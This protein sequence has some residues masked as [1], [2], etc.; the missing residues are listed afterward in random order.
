MLT[1]IRA[2]N[3]KSWKDTGEIR[4]AP[5]TGFFGT[6]SSGKT[7]LLQM[8]LLLKQTALSRDINLI[9][10]TYWD[11]NDYLNL[12]TLPELIFAAENTLH[13]EVGWQLAESLPLPE[14]EHVEPVQHLTFSTE[15]V[16]EITELKQRRNY[17]QG[18][19]YEGD[20]GFLAE[21]TRNTKDSYTVRAE[22]NGSEFARP[23]GRPR[24]RFSPPIKCYGFSSEAVLYYT[25]GS[26]LNQLG[27]EFERLFS[28][29]YHLGPLREYP[30]RTYSW[31]GEEPG[32]VG[33][34]GETAIPALLA[35]GST[36]V[37][38]TGKNRQMTLEQRIAKWLAE[39]GLV[40]SFRTERI[41]EN[42]PY[43]RVLVRRH[44]NSAEVPLTDVGFGVSQVLPVLVL[45]YY[46]PEGSTLVLEQPEIH[47]HPAVQSVLA[48]VLIDA[49]Q[50]RNIQVILESHSEYL[51]RRIQRHLSENRLE[52]DK[53]A[54]YFCNY[55]EDR[56]EIAPL[57]LDMFGNIQNWPKDFFGD[58]TGEMLAIA[59]AGLK[60]RVGVG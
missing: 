43:Y 20:N 16:T 12:G 1:K 39:M 9:L 45:A 15:I 28:R 27:Y 18:I 51:L 30:Q 21:M 41:S 25:N 23:Q 44:K 33:L 50:R 29:V 5:L 8:L 46:C 48:D 14:P 6:N 60:R 11:R 55:V 38:K 56:S 57:E 3:F 31:A 36:R 2:Q 10:R 26:V 24:A 40:A 52:V 37:Y 54:F 32:D 49:I 58:L 42:A 34:K 59:E 53:T 35:R 4:I 19:R 22:V 7:S 13:F 17:V 47:L